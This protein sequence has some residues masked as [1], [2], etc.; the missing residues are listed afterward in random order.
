M[1]QFLLIPL[2]LVILLKANGQAKDSVYFAK[3]K[4]P[5]V[6]QIAIRNGKYKVWT[7]KVGNGNIKLL[8]LHGGPGTSPEYFENFPL[9]LKDN[10]TIYYYSQLGT[11]FS[12][13]PTDTLLANV[14]KFA[15]DV[16]EVRKGLGL[17]SFY[18]LGHSWGNFLAQVYAAK[19]QKHL[20]GLILCNADIYS[21]GKNQE[22]QG[23]L[24]ANIIDSIPE[25]K[26]Y[27]DSMRY[28]LLNNYTN[29]ELMGEIMEKAFPLFI[30]NHYCRLDSLPEPVQRSKIHSSGS[31]NE[32]S[33]YL[34]YKMNQ[35]DFEPYLKKISIPVLFIGSKYDYIPPYNYAK[36][37]KVMNNKNVD[38]YI[39]PNGS[40]F[41]MW[42]DADN[43]FNAIK[44]FVQ[45]V[46]K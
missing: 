17:E 14:P 12:D 23:I 18:L 36:M 31:T 29:P 34:T 30:R 32:V 33:G 45:K 2:L 26:Q 46:E 40:H 9:Y 24:F 4:E 25:F 28:G 27:G 13:Q 19:Y 35:F 10:Y 41:D 42:D 11:Y 37:K 43:F 44:T 38:I 21:T 7:Q 3:M 20:K 15:E 16:E 5:G 6:K 22:Y 39:C 1:K 8:L